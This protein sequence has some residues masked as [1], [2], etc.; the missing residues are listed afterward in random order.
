M[1]TPANYIVVGYTTS[2][3]LLIDL[4]LCG[5]LKAQ[6]IARQIMQDYPDV[7]DCLIAES[8]PHHYHLVY[9]DGLTWGRIVHIIETLAELQIVE[10]KY[11]SVRKFRR[12]LT[13]RVSE[14]TGAVRYHP[15]PR[16]RLIIQSCHK[17]NQRKGIRAYLNVL[18]A[19][20]EAN[21]DRIP[22][23]VLD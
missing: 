10:D 14:K 1:T 3:H 23:E 18:R 4:D 17:C 5:W 12:D 19:F 6:K 2:D 13:L 15:A 22:K 21:Y 16:P 11:L 20:A 7:G 9:D 8:S